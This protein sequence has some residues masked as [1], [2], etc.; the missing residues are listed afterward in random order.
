M[1]KSY[2]L[3]SEMSRR[4]T[5]KEECIQI[6]RRYQHSDSIYPPSPLQLEPWHTIIRSL[7]CHLLHD[8]QPPFSSIIFSPC[9]SQNEDRFAMAC[10]CRLCT[11]S[12]TTDYPIQD[13][14]DSL[15]SRNSTGKVERTS[16]MTAY[17]PCLRTSSLTSSQLTDLS[18]ASSIPE[19][20]LTILFSR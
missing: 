5:Q 15:S 8:N 9:L 16:R 1:S 19:L 14:R 12:I 6:D 11:S 13:I 2:A 18:K 3:S 10:A 17:T 7:R 20:E 4:V